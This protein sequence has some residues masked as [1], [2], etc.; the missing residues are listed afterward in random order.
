M[1]AKS[2]SYKARSLLRKEI[3]G[4]EMATS[5]LIVFDASVIFDACSD[6]VLLRTWNK[7][8]I[9]HQLIKTVLC[10]R[11]QIN[12]Y[13]SSL[14]LTYFQLK[15]KHP[16]EGQEAFLLRLVLLLLL[17]RTQQGTEQQEDQC[18]CWC[19]YRC[20]DSA[21]GRRNALHQH[22]SLRF[23]FFSSPV[24]DK[25]C[26]QHSWFQRRRPWCRSR[27]YILTSSL[28]LSIYTCLVW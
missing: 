14:T 6:L 24:P 25:A 17:G 18:Q 2:S 11:T 23:L 19:C 7:Y 8:L 28:S 16:N 20:W 21:F 26:R 9:Y 15:K 1:L 13:S 5:L 12:S 22:V 3:L 4:L 10:I 27:R